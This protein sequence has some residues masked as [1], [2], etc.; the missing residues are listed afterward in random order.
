VWYVAGV[1]WEMTIRLHLYSP[2]T[3]ANNEK[4]KKI[5]EKQ[6]IYKISRSD[7]THTVE[8]MD[9][10]VFSLCKL[11]TWYFEVEVKH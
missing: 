3:V 7:T 4:K 10:I 8:T 9:K 2:E 11:F 1:Y 5:H 6:T